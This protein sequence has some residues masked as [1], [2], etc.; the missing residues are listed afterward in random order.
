MVRNGQHRSPVLVSLSGHPFAS[1]YLVLV[2]GVALGVQ[3]LREHH[4]LKQDDSRHRVVQSQLVLVQL[5]ENR[6]DVQMGV[7]LHLRSLQLGLNRE[8]LLQE[9]EGRAHLADPAV[10]ASHVIEGHGLSK[11]V[12]LAKLL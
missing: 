5:G 11:L 12:V 2:V 1:F 4:L 6:T 9:V 8:C 7:R 10:V 3:L